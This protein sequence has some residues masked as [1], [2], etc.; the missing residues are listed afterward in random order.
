MYIK[1]ERR[2]CRCKEGPTWRQRT[3]W[4]SHDHLVITRFAGVTPGL[5]LCT[6]GHHFT[7]LVVHMKLSPAGWAMS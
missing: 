3:K 7:D 2:D 1:H 5:C 4:T 6:F